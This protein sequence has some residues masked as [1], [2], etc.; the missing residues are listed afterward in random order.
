[1]NSADSSRRLE[2]AVAAA[3][4]SSGVIAISYGFAEESPARI[5][6]LVFGLVAILIAV[7][8]RRRAATASVLT[9]IPPRLARF[10]A[11]FVPT[12]AFMAFALYTIIGASGLLVGMT[13]PTSLLLLIAVSTVVA[14]LNLVTLLV[15]LRHL[16]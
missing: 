4:G 2:R 3:L 11:L 16:H 15:N 13:L 1:M 7:V 12:I 9:L 5:F 14:F 6:W 10:L 8:G